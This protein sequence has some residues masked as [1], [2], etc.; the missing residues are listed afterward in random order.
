MT[1]TAPPVC[2]TLLKQRRATGQDAK[3]IKSTSHT[4]T[5]SSIDTYQHYL[6]IPL[7]GLQDL[8]KNNNFFGWDIY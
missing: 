7:P 1:L 6:L 4:H 5:L 2:S 8:P 3:Q